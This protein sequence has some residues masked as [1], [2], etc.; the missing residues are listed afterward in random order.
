[1]GRLTV[2]AVAAAAIAMAGL[3]W[4]AQ[5]QTRGEAGLKAAAQD[6]TLV[7]KAACGGY[8]GIHG[9]GPGWTWRYGRRGWACYRCWW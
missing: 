4:H 2:L 8:T 1:M 3:A 6:F 9:C 5:A 7:H